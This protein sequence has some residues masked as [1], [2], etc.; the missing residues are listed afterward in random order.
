M[1]M[2]DIPERTDALDPEE[3][4]ILARIADL[5]NEI[6]QLRVSLEETRKMK[7]IL[8]LTG[9]AFRDEAVRF[10]V[11]RLG[12]Q[13][14]VSDESKDGFWLGVD[15]P[16]E[17][18][19]FGEVRESSDGNVTREM[20]ARVMIDRHD[21]AKADDFPAL[22]IVNTFCGTEGVE[23]RDLPV[24]ADVTKRAHEDH[25]MVVRVLDLVRL[26]QKEQSGFAG[27]KD[28][29][30]AIRLGGGWFE[31]NAQLASKINIE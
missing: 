30:E 18:W 16:G 8:F 17:E 2:A 9:P 19:G 10:L 12:V 6:S 13:A 4:Q 1:V 15:T 5:E 22:L 14:R 24:P 29:Q 3:Q 25:I 23:E 28:F 26:R 7:Q 11:T 20:V 21:G 27:I 31:V